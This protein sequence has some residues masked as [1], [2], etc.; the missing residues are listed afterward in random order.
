MLMSK[1][2]H[3]SSQIEK[4]QSGNVIVQ[5]AG[6]LCSARDADGVPTLHSNAETLHQDMFAFRRVIMFFSH[7]GRVRS[8]RLE[9]VVSLWWR[10]SAT[11]FLYG[12]AGYLIKSWN[13]YIFVNFR[14]LRPSFQ[15]SYSMRSTSDMQYIGLSLQ[16]LSHA[17]DP[18]VIN[19]A[20]D[21]GD[22]WYGKRIRTSPRYSLQCPCAPDLTWKY[23]SIR[24]IF[25]SPRV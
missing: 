17:F 7:K 25:L 20:T 23:L 5:A 1:N 4:L 18:T 22:R 2:D 21:G 24:L 16:G 19:P 6:W 10:G 14:K 15:L 8:F 13:P 3:N 12:G 11:P 9:A